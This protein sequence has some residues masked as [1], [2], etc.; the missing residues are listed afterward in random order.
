[1]GQRYLLIVAD[2][3]GYSAERDAGIRD[4]FKAGAISATSLMVNGISAKDAVEEA[5]KIGMPVGE[6]LLVH[7]ITFCQDHGFV[8]NLSV[9]LCHHP[10]KYTCLLSIPSICMSVLP[11]L[12]IH[13]P[14]DTLVCN[15]KQ[16]YI[17]ILSLAYTES[18]PEI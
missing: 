18:F 16:K 1:M 10:Y 4:C 11:K 14:W 5:K 8:S 15:F 13:V 6:L 2:D 3:Y 12:A 7:G 9:F 17:M